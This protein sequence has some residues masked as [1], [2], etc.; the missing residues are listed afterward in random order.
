MVATTKFVLIFIFSG[1]L[2]S[3]ENDFQL[4]LVVEHKELLGLFDYM[5][6]LPKEYRLW[7]IRLSSFHLT[8]AYLESNT[9]A[10]RARARTHTYTHTHQ[11]SF[12][13]SVCLSA[14]Q[15]RSQNSWAGAV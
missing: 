8:F 9:T 10:S 11:N 12:L 2:F 6:L 13:V 7:P 15:E 5:F 14:S 3:G 4:E 1:I